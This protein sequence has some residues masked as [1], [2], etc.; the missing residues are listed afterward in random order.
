VA[1][2]NITEVK[3]SNIRVILEV[4][5]HS[6]QIDVD[7]YVEQVEDIWRSNTR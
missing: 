3:N 4:V 2:K 5:S 7:R 1:G 6:W